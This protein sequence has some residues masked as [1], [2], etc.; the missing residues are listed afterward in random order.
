MS[1]TRWIIFW[2]SCVFFYSGI[3]SETGFA[4]CADLE[5]KCFSTKSRYK[6]NPRF[7][8]KD[9][10]QHTLVSACG[11]VQRTKIFASRHILTN[12]KIKLQDSI[13]GNGQFQNVAHSDSAIINIELEITCTKIIWLPACLLSHSSLFIPPSEY[14]AATSD[15]KPVPSTGR[16]GLTGFLYEK[17]GVTGA[18]TLG[19][20][21]GAYLIS[22]ELYVINSEVHAYTAV[23]Y[24]SS[25]R[26]SSIP[27]K[28]TKSIYIVP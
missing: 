2:M 7:I 6:V 25:D 11:L 16:G 14:P 1:R 26:L 15:S 23:Y 9:A 13:L 20:G 17:T 19:V 5:C 10:H 8:P 12:F 4:E 21:I 18:W 28:S 27:S 22:K 3:Q 24:E